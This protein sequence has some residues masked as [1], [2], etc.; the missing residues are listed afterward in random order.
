MKFVTKSYDYKFRK[1]DETFSTSHI[2]TRANDHSIS[3][4]GCDS[5]VLF[6]SSIFQIVKPPASVTAKLS[7]RD[8]DKL[9][10]IM[11]SKMNE[12]SK[13]HMVSALLQVNKRSSPVREFKV[14]SEFIKR[15]KPSL[16]LS[17]QG[18]A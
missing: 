14:S 7:S 13:Q 4:S 1:H 6:A 3:R 2:T 18:F 17:E 9:D 15:Q 12:K 10:R 5:E 8:Q 16:R 11:V